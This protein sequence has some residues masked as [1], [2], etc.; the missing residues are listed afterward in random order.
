[1]E[2]GPT[3]GSIEELRPLAALT[4]LCAENRIFLAACL[5]L[6]KRILIVNV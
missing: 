1:M 3:T 5:V 2:V 4:M 6:S